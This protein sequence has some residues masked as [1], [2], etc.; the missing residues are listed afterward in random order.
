MA[1][2]FK[3]QSEEAKVFFQESLSLFRQAGNQREMALVLD[4]L[5]ELAWSLKDEARSR[6]AFSSALKIAVEISA[7]P[8]VLRILSD[9]CLLT[10]ESGQKED[11]LS[12]AQFILGHRAVEYETRQKAEQL[13]ARLRPGFSP[14]EL[15]AIGK[16]AGTLEWKNALENF[17][18]P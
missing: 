2:F 18:A 3:G 1:A 7:V 5:G 6:E 4:H 9:L 13:A 8:V 17:P 12:W 14:E 16:K 11:A 15:A 10:S